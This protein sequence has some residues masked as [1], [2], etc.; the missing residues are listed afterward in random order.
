GAAVFHQDRVDQGTWAVRDGGVRPSE[1]RETSKDDSTEGAL[2][3]ARFKIVSGKSPPRSVEDA[4][5]SSDDRLPARRPTR[6]KNPPAAPPAHSVGA[7]GS[8][9]HIQE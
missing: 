4:L 2:T 9:E 7:S 3:G 5:H 1:G 8:H 6:A